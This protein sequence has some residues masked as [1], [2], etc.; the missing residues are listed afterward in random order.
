MCLSTCGRLAAWKLS[1][2]TCLHS[3]TYRDELLCF[4]AVAVTTDFCAMGKTLTLATQDWHA[5]TGIWSRYTGKCPVLEVV[6]L[7]RFCLM[8]SSLVLAARTNGP[9]GPWDS[10]AAG[11]RGVGYSIIW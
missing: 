6:W 10:A 11:L 2:V 4:S 7:H 5:E 1:K 9:S 8:G 3:V